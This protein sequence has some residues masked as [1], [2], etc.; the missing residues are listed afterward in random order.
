M[1]SRK[2]RL[3]AFLELDHDVHVRRHDDRKTI[4]GDGT[5]LACQQMLRDRLLSGIDERHPEQLDGRE[6]VSLR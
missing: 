1:R 2:P 5:P 4:A 3:F 6:G